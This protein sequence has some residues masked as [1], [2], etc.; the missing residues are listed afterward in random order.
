M[1]EKVALTDAHDV[2]L[3]ED[4][5]IGC[6]YIDR[7]DDVLYFINKKEGLAW[8]LPE[9]YQKTPIFVL[10]P[11][12]GYR[13]GLI[14]VSTMGEVELQYHHDFGSAAGMWG[15]IDTEGNTVIPPQYIF[16]TRFVD[17]E[18]VVCKGEWSVN[19]QNEYWCHQEMWGVINEQGEE[20]V[21][22]IYDELFTVADTQRYLICH[23]GGWKEGEYI[24]F[25]TQT[26]EE[27]ALGEFQ[28]DFAYMFNECFYQ[29]GKIIFC[30]HIPGEETDYISCYSTEKRA[31][32]LYRKEA[33]GRTFQGET[34][35][36][37]TTQDGDEIIIF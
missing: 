12:G 1:M 34:K 23:K 24:I 6:G 7:E 27:Y 37:I 31:W 36:S 11:C 14:M 21:P 13:D 15:W 29:D 33:Q 16:A 4:D 20:K 22:C 3:Y 25:D 32:L 28:F 35:K 2:F 18:A 19:D 10:P 26:K 30:E 9:E 17:G 5:D 8:K